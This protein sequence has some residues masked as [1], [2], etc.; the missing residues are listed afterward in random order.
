MNP[1]AGE[2]NGTVTSW[3][4]SAVPNWLK[5]PL[6]VAIEMG[7]VRLLSRQRRLAVEDEAAWAKEVR[8]QCRGVLD[9]H[10]QIERLLRFNPLRR[11]KE[12]HESA[13]HAN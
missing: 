10:R 6:K 13:N 12:H 3:L 1:D 11:D 9:G 8:E 5:L 7:G 2:G 4:T